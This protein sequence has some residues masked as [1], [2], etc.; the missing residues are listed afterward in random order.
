MFRN[1]IY[2][3]PH[4]VKE[5]YGLTPND[6][7]QKGWE[8]TKLNVDDQWVKSR[9]DGVNI[10]VIDTGC[11]YNHPDIKD[12]IIGGFNVINNTKNFMDD[13]GHGSHVCGTISAI[14]NGIG[15][16]GV[17]PK[18]KIYAIKAMDS[19]GSASQE[20]IAKGIDLAINA[21]VDIITMSLGSKYEMKKIKKSIENAISNNILIFCAAGNSGINE[22]I[23]YPAR[24]KNTISIGA[25]D[26]NLN[27]TNFTCSGDE[28][29]FLSPGH[30]IMSI[31]PNNRYALMSGTSMSNPFA[32]GCA[33]L[34]ISYYRQQTGKKH[35]SQSEMIEILKNNTLNLVNTNFREKKYQGYGII[36]P[37][38]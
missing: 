11:D 21:G 14:D 35:F 24:D 31:I 19:N 34:Y 18:S 4:I 30:N 10:A 3:L 7:Q 27:R 37:V 26:E 13:N 8:I 33:A 36:R 32:V 9:G 12:N 2:L 38:L 25:V 29:D 22:E 1:K 28:L 5:Y 23:M 20:N 6:P 17:A 16:V 15:M